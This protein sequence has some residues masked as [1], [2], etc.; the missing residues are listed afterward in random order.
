MPRDLGKTQ[1]G[2]LPITKD[3]GQGVVSA[4][5]NYPIHS[6]NEHC[7]GNCHVDLS[8]HVDETSDGNP[9]FILPNIADRNVMMKKLEDGISRLNDLYYKLKFAP[10]LEEYKK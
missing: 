4:H 3:V 2:V 9:F 10:D 1:S 6:N 8:G 7:P 5:P